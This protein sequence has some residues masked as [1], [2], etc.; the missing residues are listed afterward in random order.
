MFRNMRQNVNFNIKMCI[1][2]IK[3]CTSQRSYKL[4]YLFLTQ[5]QQLLAH[6]QI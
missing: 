2:T 6:L 5:Q 4:F 1:S 3:M